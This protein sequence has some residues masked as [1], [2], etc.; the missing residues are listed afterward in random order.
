LKV[1]PVRANMASYISNQLLH[2]LLNDY[3][4]RSDYS[5]AKELRFKKVRL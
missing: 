5:K 4:L 2:I 3:L 1:L